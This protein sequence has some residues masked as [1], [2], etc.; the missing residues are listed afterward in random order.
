MENINTKVSFVCLTKEDKILL[1]QEGGRLAMGL[2]S[3][4]GGHVD[5]GESF[6]EAAVRE[7]MEES[8]YEIILE[9]V[10]YH[11]LITNKEYKGT[12]GDTD[13]VEITIFKGLITGGNLQIDNQALDLKW[14]TKE[15]I[16]KLSL[17]W[18]FL[19]DLI[20]SL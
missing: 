11:S 4:P 13:Q 17:R 9:K 15:E 18:N 1:L 2:W 14:M 10:I 6:E 12:K 5:E 8:G 19:K 20:I 3:F 7:A 16:L